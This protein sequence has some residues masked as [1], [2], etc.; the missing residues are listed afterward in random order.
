M[1]WPTLVLL[2]AKEGDAALYP[3]IGAIWQA[4]ARDLRIERI[5]TKHHM[6]E[7]V[8]MPWPRSCEP[9]LP[10]DDAAHSTMTAP[11]VPN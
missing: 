7:E 3:D 11:A 9:F 8:P 4:R 10:A 1:A 5:D 2:A 6:A